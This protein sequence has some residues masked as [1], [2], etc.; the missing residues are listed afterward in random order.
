[1]SGV[2]NKKEVKL[3]AIAA[4]PPAI[5]PTL[6]R[7]KSLRPHQRRRASTPQARRLPKSDDQ[8]TSQMGQNWT[9]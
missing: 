3:I 8:S 5:A 7:S 4:N 1:V 2:S 6:I 9:A